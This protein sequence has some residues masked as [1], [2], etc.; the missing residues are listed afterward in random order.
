MI[1]GVSTS[2]L[3]PE[4]TEQALL[5]LGRM[6]IGAAEIFLNA[7]SEWE[8]PFVRELGK[9]AADHGIRILSLHPFISGLEPL[10]FFSDYERRLYD[11]IELYKNY[12]HAANL[13]GAD[14][15]VFHGDRKESR[16]PIGFYAERFARLIEAGRAMGITVAHENV[17]RCVGCAPGFFRALRGQLPQ[18]KFVLDVKQCIRAGCSTEDMLE[19]MGDGVIHLHLSD[20]A[21][22]RDCL[23]LGEGTMDLAALLKQMQ[24]AGFDGN[25]VLELYRDN[26]GTYSQLADS[27]R[28]I[29]GCING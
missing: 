6:Q 19:A 1:A 13:L 24:A 12:F 25:V 5:C 18:A 22:G 20:H 7:P 15:L 16:R 4:K 10:L 26:Y 8:E 2:C 11:G 17:A 3:Y 21:P 28:Q 9:I 14:I 27:Y 29:L 23:P